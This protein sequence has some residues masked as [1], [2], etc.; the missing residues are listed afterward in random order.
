M[1]TRECQNNEPNYLAI[2]IGSAESRKCN[3]VLNA[4]MLGREWRGNVAHATIV[5][6]SL[7]IEGIF[8]FEARFPNC[9]VFFIFSE[10]NIRCSGIEKH[11]YFIHM[12]WLE[13]CLARNISICIFLL[14]LPPNIL[15]LLCCCCCWIRRC[16]LRIECE[17][18]F[19]AFS[20]AVKIGIF[21]LSSNKTANGAIIRRYNTEYIICYIL[22]HSFAPFYSSTCVQEPQ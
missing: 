2:F 9:F 16:L 21:S 22:N 19:E 1:H 17:I 20:R 18:M 15:W 5:N 7:C 6:E 10:W 12:S 4:A 8:S 11:E 3:N 14:I 13:T